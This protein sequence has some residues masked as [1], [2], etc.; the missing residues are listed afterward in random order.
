MKRT[1]PW[2]LFLVLLCAT[3]QSQ[4][5]RSAEKAEAT[6]APKVVAQNT[7]ARKAVEGFGA[8]LVLAD[9]PQAFIQEWLKPA[10]GKPELWSAA[11]AKRGEPLAAF[12]MFAGCLPDR[13]GDCQAEVDFRVYRPDGSLYAE[14]TGLELW[15]KAAP[16]A[17]NTQLG[18][19][20][21]LIRIRPDD[22]A[23]EYR[24]KASVRDLNRK[25]SFEIE[26]KFTVR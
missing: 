17:S 9:R 14:R 21:M 1:L 4:E 18:A 10:S 13:K 5:K 25:V 23:G 2:P 26:E 12:I 20:N 11:E 8:H 7:A 22:P 6:P 3:C 24:V 19:A 16:P 15:K